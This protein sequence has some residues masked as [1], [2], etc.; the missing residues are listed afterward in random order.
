MVAELNALSSNAA[1]R[2]Y[3]WGLD[4]SGT[5]QGAGGV[6]GLLTATDSGGSYS[7]AFDGNGNVA[8]YVDFSSGAT[9]ATYD[10]DPFGNEIMAEGAAKD[11]FPHGFSGKYA[12]SETGLVYYGF[13]YYQ[14]TTGRWLSRDP[15]EEEGGMNL[16][17]FCSN[18]AGNRADALG[19]FDGVVSPYGPGT[20]LRRP[21]PAPNGFAG[22][23]AGLEAI[24]K[25]LA[26]PKMS[27][28]YKATTLLAPL[29]GG[30]IE[31]DVTF[32]GSVAPCACSNDG[33]MLQF[34]GEV[35]VEVRG[36]FG[37][38]LGKQDYE[39]RNPS[40]RPSHNNVYDRSKPGSGPITGADGRV[41][42][43]T[44]TSTKGKTEFSAMSACKTEIGLSVEIGAKFTAGS[45]FVGAQAKLPFGVIDKDGAR[46]SFEPSA[47]WN[48]GRSPI[49]VR[50]ELYGRGSAQVKI[51]FLG[52]N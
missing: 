40:N 32:N 50:A 42:N 31:L 41:N 45:A 1:V 13:R 46:W 8:A 26:T 2:T 4:L 49:G 11:A 28:G 14:P 24:I 25:S 39:I 36:G 18:D 20:M 22:G 12:D 33:V 9:S 6:G 23:G 7:V 15:L 51:A 16:Y 5:M 34:T 52:T 44:I 27:Y 48:F 10:Y 47:N 21:T 3:A 29:P 30:S 37:Y 17:G 19:E 35:V 38:I 43:P